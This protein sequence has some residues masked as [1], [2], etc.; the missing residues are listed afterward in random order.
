M[1]RR[2]GVALLLGLCAGAVAAQEPQD[3]L[4]NMR[5]ALQTRDF[6]GEVVLLREGQLEALS[7]DHVAAGDRTD[8]TPLN[9]ADGELSRSGQQVTFAADRVVDL[10]EALRVDA[11]EFAQS[12]Q[13]RIVG[14]DRVAGR[15]VQ[16]IEAL[17]R[18]AWRFGRRFWVDRES[19][20]PLRSAIRAAD[21]NIIEQWMF[22]RI[23]LRRVAPP[24]Y[25]DRAQ[26]EHFVGPQSESLAQTR[27]RIDG[28]PDGFG[29]LAASRSPDSEHLVLADG[30]SK[31]SVFVE[32]LKRDQQVLTGAHR[33]GALHVFGRVIPGHQVVVVGEV[34]AATVERIAQGVTAVSGG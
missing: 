15:P 24:V 19:G 13:L 22:T 17:P 32:P 25:G 4:A 11:P 30:M 9:R 8:I 29:L 27:Y 34:P 33:R 14:E 18:D 6:A 16:V 12:Y 26:P 20:L 7:V 2:A 28:A 1:F 5:E 10:G 3:L 23:E 31:V 21:G